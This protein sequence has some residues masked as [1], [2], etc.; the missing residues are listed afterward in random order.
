M[1]RIGDITYGN[2]YLNISSISYV[3]DRFTQ[4]RLGMLQLGFLYFHSTRVG[5]DIMIKI[6][7]GLFQVSFKIGLNII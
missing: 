6:Y 5:L 2:R 4:I 7:F 1:N 3:V